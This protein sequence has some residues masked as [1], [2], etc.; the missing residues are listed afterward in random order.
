MKL[1]YAISYGYGTD[2]DD[3]IAALEKSVSDMMEDGFEPIGS[4]TI[5][6]DASLDEPFFY[7]C[8]PMLQREEE[9]EAQ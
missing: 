5:M 2:F 9:Q 8:Q 6:Q 7:A 3:V 4:M 1:N